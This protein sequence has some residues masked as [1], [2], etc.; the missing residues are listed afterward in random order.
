[1]EWADAVQKKKLVWNGLLGQKEASQ[2]M[3]LSKE[4]T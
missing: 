1:M 2:P 4:P 3:R